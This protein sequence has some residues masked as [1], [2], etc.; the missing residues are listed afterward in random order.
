[1]GSFFT[2]HRNLSVGQG[3]LDR[4]ACKQDV[5]SC[6]RWKQ[7]NNE[8][9]A[10]IPLCK[11]AGTLI[12]DALRAYQIQH[13]PGLLAPAPAIL[14]QWQPLSYMFQ[15]THIHTHNSTCLCPWEF[16]GEES[17]A[18]TRGTTAQWLEHLLS[19]MWKPCSPHTVTRI[20]RSN[21]TTFLAWH[22]KGFQ[23]AL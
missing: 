19:S 5:S 14:S 20:L 9:K 17:E 6:F 16:P 23:A 12:L 15:H 22:H 8:S 18:E 10:R 7:I 3:K 4:E 13:D 1:M 21:S 2:G 11:A